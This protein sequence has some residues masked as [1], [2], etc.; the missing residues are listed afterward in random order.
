MDTTFQL[1]SFKVSPKA[2]ITLTI[3]IAIV[4]LVYKFYDEIADVLGFNDETSTDKSENADKVI[5]TVEKE[6]RK[7]K[8][9]KPN[10]KHQTIALKLFKALDWYNTDEETVYTQFNGLTPNDVRLVVEAYGTKRLLYSGLQWTLL[11]KDT[12]G[13]L[14]EHLRLVLNDTEF[15]KVR[16]WLIAAGFEQKPRK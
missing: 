8:L 6:N 10:S 9:P 16:P 15:N 4:V 12:V 3:V 14:V 5:D 13:T 2:I 1:G 11:G 7:R